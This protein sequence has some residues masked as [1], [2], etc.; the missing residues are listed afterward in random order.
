MGNALGGTLNPRMTLADGCP[1]S[2]SVCYVAGMATPP[3]D[4]NLPMRTPAPL[5]QD[6]LGGLISYTR[7]SR[8][9]DPY[10]EPLVPDF[11]QMTPQQAEAFFA[12][13]G[14]GKAD[15]LRQEYTRQRMGPVGLGAGGLHRLGAKGLGM[16]PGAISK[17]I[18]SGGAPISKAQNIQAA[19]QNPPLGP[20][21][22]LG[23]LPTGQTPLPAATPPSPS[24]AVNM[25]KALPLDQAFKTIKGG[26]RGIGQ[27]GVPAR[28]GHAADEIRRL[29]KYPI[30][31]PQT[32]RTLNALDA[33]SKFAK[34][35]PGGNLQM[36]ATPGGRQAVGA[37]TGLSAL[38][39]LGHVGA[40]RDREYQKQQQAARDANVA[41]QGPQMSLPRPQGANMSMLPQGAP[42]TPTPLTPQVS[43][44]GAPAP[45]AKTPTAAPTPAGGYEVQKGDWLGDIV[46][47]DFLSRGITDP[48]LSQVQKRVEEV[49]KEIGLA[50]P[51]KLQTFTQS[52]K[53]IA[54]IA[55]GISPKGQWG[56]MFGGKPKKAEPKPAPATGEFAASERRALETGEPEPGWEKAAG[57]GKFAGKGDVPFVPRTPPSEEVI[58]AVKEIKLQRDTSGIPAPIAEE[59]PRLMPQTRLGKIPSPLAGP[60]MFGYPEEEEEGRLSRNFQKGGGITGGIPGKDSVNILAQQGEYVLPKPVVEAIQTGKPPPQGNAPFVEL[61]RNWD[62]QTPE[63]KRYQ[64]ELGA[65]LAAQ[66]APASG[67]RK[68]GGVRGWTGGQPQKQHRSPS[69]SYSRAPRSRGGAPAQKTSPVSYTQPQ[70]QQSR[71]SRPSFTAGASTGQPYV[72]SGP[73]GRGAYRAPQA[74]SESVLRNRG[75]RQVRGPNAGSERLAAAAR[76]R[77]QQAE[78]KRR[79]REVALS[80]VAAQNAPAGGYQK[81]GGVPKS[82][83]RPKDYGLLPGQIQERKNRLFKGLGYG[84]EGGPGIHWTELQKILNAS[85]VLSYTD[86]PMEFPER[87]IPPMLRRINNPNFRMRV[88]KFSPYPATREQAWSPYPQGTPGKW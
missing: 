68:G 87:A 25:Q 26:G 88:Q 78:L 84:P 61:F 4:L 43:P 32:Q 20:M 80:R 76:Y 83:E 7:R 48:S 66:S 71:P 40:E 23:S 38:G 45:T 6:P 47:A 17:T 67:M 22:K 59:E 8:M 52:Q 36:L 10:A 69:T 44:Q 65:A 62:P 21:S 77:K 60:D 37:M 46:V 53:P 39:A 41:W 9:T 73:L 56:K 72:F 75:G 12:A 74:V 11:S 50:D 24:A 13:R 82:I 30:N 28:T 55:K 16:G 64:Q 42:P 85:P 57:W 14:M 2:N 3:Y 54:S 31:L 63:G 5:V 18:P 19:M 51:K 79:Q 34:L 1:N 27:G 29:S 58:D 70:K 81:G 33:A 49:Q 15:P 35:S 86:A